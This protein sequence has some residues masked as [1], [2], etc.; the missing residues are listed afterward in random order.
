MPTKYVNKYGEN[1]ILSGVHQPVADI[2][3]DLSNK[4]KD[5]NLQ[6]NGLKVFFTGDSITALNLNPPYLNCGFGIFGTM[7]SG[8]IVDNIGTVA[9]PGFNIQ[10]IIDAADGINVSGDYCVVMAGANGTG[11]ASQTFE[12]YQSQL[13]ALWTKLENKGFKL[14]VCTILPHDGYSQAA[15]AVRMCVNDWIKTQS[16]N[17]R[18]PFNAHKAIFKTDTYKWRALTFQDDGSGVGVHPNIRGA[19]YIGSELAKIFTALPNIKPSKAS[20]NILDPKVLNA[21]PAMVGNNA[22]ATNGFSAGTGF[23][24]TGPYST[25]ITR[26]STLV[27]GTCSCATVQSMA[28]ETNEFTITAAFTGTDSFRVRQTFHF[29]DTDWNT[30]PVWSTPTLGDYVLEGSNLYRC[31]SLG[32]G[33]NAGTKPTFTTTIGDVITDGTVKW[34]CIGPVADGAYFRAY[35][36]FEVTALTG[37]FMFSLQPTLSDTVVYLGANKI[38]NN[39]VGL[40]TGGSKL[41][42]PWIETTES[43]PNIKPTGD[44]TISSPLI[45]IGHAGANLLKL[46]SMEFWVYGKNGTAITLKL[47]NLELRLE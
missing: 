38:I 26:N 9:T 29:N 22:N 23:T 10:Q 47:K 45:Q 14:I 12:T 6:N 11:L 33:T 2:L 30:W 24:G 34:L 37:E 25:D 17:G 42:M 27:T 5:G 39:G 13:T 20:G 46:G 28:S 19:Y 7:L 3:N 43:Y 31:I 21:N 41:W 15:N 32:I 44:V 8:G 18:I 4:V 1:V 16:V 35:A 36:T 40:S